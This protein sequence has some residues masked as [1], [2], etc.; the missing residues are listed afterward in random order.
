MKVWIVRAD[1]QDDDHLCSIWSTKEA[2][3]KEAAALSPNA[4]TSYRVEEFEV[5]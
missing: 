2:A 3:E 5:Q 4:W 1:Q